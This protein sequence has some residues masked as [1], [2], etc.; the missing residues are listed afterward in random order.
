M[1]AG[2]VKD[3]LLTLAGVVGILSILWFAAAVVFGLSIVVVLTGSMAPG[4]PT[5]SA[6]LVHDDVA[7]A[8]LAV[9]DVVTVPQVGQPLPVT[10]RI[11]AIDV[12][13]GDSAA[14]SITLQGDDNDTPDRQPYLVDTVQRAIVGF[15][16]LGFVI[17]VLQTPLMIGGA[18]LAVAGLVVWAFWPQRPADRT[19][20]TR[21]RHRAGP[22]PAETSEPAGA[23][24]T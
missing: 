20:P 9:G 23:R 2:R 18:T 22:D 17:R 5:G 7:A 8:D 4:L 16:T 3:T 6:I 14:R 19:N 21:P 11:I 15:P 12:V 10:H 13:P 24:R 1:T